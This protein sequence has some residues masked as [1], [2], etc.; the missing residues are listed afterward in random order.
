MYKKI[1]ISLLLIILILKI[2][3]SS[4]A[5]VDKSPF[6]T[7][8]TLRSLVEEII[9]DLGVGGQSIKV[10]DSNNQYIGIFAGKDS[11]NYLIFLS[12]LNKTISLNPL[13]LSTPT[14]NKFYESGCDDQTF[15]WDK[16]YLDP[17]QLY[18]IS[19]SLYY[20]SPNKE[21][22]L[23]EAFMIDDFVQPP[24]C[25]KTSFSQYIKMIQVEGY[26]FPQYQAPLQLRYE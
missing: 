21:D 6:V 20:S 5:A 10:Y 26:T 24:Q 3:I 25:A 1:L 13:T 11:S 22:I 17:N 9:K 2:P 15:Y 16:N 12:D 14:Y 4:L 7:L 23:L 8:D 19:S 18:L